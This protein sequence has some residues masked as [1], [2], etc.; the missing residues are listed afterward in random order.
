[1]LTNSR[2]MGEILVHE[3]DWADWVDWAECWASPPS[4]WKGFGDGDGVVE[5][6]APHSLCSAGPMAG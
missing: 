1:M 3:A 4:K 2:I 6:G 5:L